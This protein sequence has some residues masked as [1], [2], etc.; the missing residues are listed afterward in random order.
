[1][2]KKDL[3]CPQCKKPLLRLYSTMVKSVT[4][5][6]GFRL[7]LRSKEHKEGATRADRFRS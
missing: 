3:K 4:C 7:D 6:C 2:L 1:M 5:S